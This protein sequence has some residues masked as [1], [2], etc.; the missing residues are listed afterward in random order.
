MQTQTNKQTTLI[1]VTGLPLP[2]YITLHFLA[3]LTSN[4]RYRLL[5]NFR[6][7]V[8]HIKKT[9]TSEGRTYTLPLQFIR[10]DLVQ[11]P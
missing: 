11:V 10:S 5:G 4:P 3:R 6:I 2:S 9:Y 8:Y 1:K 7:S